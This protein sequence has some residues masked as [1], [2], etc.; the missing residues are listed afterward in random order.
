LYRG[1]Y[2]VLVILVLSGC[3]PQFQTQRGRALTPR[4]SAA[5]QLTQEGKDL[6]EAG[7]PDNALRLFEQAIGLN[8]NDGQCY[9]YIAQAWLEKGAQAE[10]REF[11]SLAR[12]YLKD[13]V[14]WTKRVI[15]QASRIDRLSP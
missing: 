6:L 10:A 9:Y 4:E 13:D 1:L 7:K 2:F 3:A 15:K 5:M 11:N 14:K 12:D 8:P